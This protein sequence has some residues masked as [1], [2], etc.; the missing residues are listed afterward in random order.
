[1]KYFARVNITI[2]IYAGPYTGSKTVQKL[3]TK[4][5]LNWIDPDGNITYFSSKINA[6][7]LYERLLYR[8]F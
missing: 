5:S 6:E 3:P 7:I 8:R 2:S 1:M 4:S